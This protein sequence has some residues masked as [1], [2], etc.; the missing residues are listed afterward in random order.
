MKFLALV[1]AAILASA[2]GSATAQTTSPNT[3]AKDTKSV[4]LTE[5][6]K[7]AAIEAAVVAKSRQ[8]TPNGFS[9]AVGADVPK[10]VY[11]H[12][13]RPEVTQETPALK[14]HLYA[15]LDSEVILVDVRNKVVAVLPL[16]EKY[17]ARAQQNHGAAEAS[18]TD[19]KG[20]S[21]A[22]GSGATGSVPS[23]TSPETIK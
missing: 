5:A 11:V 19:A 2:S 20:G 8:K 22:T 12:G 4:S 23:H 21:G 15:F 18:T 16:P 13:F 17:V 14:N 9:P 3:A 10:G 6:D 7:Q 1:A